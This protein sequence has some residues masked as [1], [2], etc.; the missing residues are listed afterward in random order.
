VIDHD[1]ALRVFYTATRSNGFDTHASQIY[2][3]REL[4]RTVSQYYQGGHITPQRPVGVSFS[5]GT[6]QP[7]ISGRLQYRPRSVAL[8]GR[9]EHFDSLVAAPLTIGLRPEMMA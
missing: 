8:Q 1:P 4:L 2:T 3:H 6:W 7:A 9:R 5:L